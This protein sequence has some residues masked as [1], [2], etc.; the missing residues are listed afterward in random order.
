MSNQYKYVFADA[1]SVLYQALPQGQAS[2][3]WQTA[4][5][6][7]SHALGL[8]NAGGDGLIVEG[9]PEEIINFVDLVHAHVH[10]EFGGTGA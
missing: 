2:A 10:K 3:D 6:T 8:F 5:L 7:E 1:G 4:E 9:R